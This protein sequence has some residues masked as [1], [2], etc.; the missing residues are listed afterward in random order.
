VAT[1]SDITGVVPFP[2]ARNSRTKKPG[3]LRALFLSRVARKKNLSGALRML[4]DVSGDVSFNIYGPLED[5]GYWEECQDLIATLPTNIQVQYQGQIEHERIGEVFAEHDL[6]LFPT[7]GENYGHVICEALGS[8]CPVLISDQTPWRNLETDG[9]G[10]DFPHEE[11]DRFRSVLQQCVDA[12]DK[13]CAA[14][15]RRAMQYAAKHASDPETIAAN[16]RL[17]QQAF[18]WT[19]SPYSNSY[20]EHRNK[21]G[22]FFPG[23]MHGIQGK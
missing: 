8:G 10:W 14:L 21:K 18:V 15:S 1:A 19:G 17:F 22:A 2:E 5:P 13:W 9:V 20:K 4:R 3:Q 12:D 7:L 11:T 16:R 6:F 23:R